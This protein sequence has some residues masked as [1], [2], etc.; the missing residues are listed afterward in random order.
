MFSRCSFEAQTV[1]IYRLHKINIQQNIQ[2][3]MT[4]L[5]FAQSSL[6][7]NFLNNDPIFTKQLGECSEFYPQSKVA[8]F[9]NNKSE[10]I[11]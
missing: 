10:K 5:L 6:N 11:G 3:F 2:N 4:L 7:H 8:L 9:D 1:L